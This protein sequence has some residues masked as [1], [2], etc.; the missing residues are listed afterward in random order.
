VQKKLNL[1][2]F[3]NNDTIANTNL[4]IKNKMKNMTKIKS[5]LRVLLLCV[6]L[7]GTSFLKAQNCAVTINN[8]FLCDVQLDISFFEL[9][10]TCTSCP[11]NPINITI[12]AGSSTLLNCSNIALWA[13][14]GTVCD[15]TATFTNP[16][17]TPAGPFFY[18]TGP[19]ALTGLPPGCGASATANI[20]VNAGT[21]DIN[22]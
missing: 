3:D 1:I 5:A 15:I 18:N 16:V 14:S 22:P 9:T 19:Q 13:C 21:I 4:K 10:P 7:V 8:N 20:V 11:G 17:P 12:V 2:L 6:F